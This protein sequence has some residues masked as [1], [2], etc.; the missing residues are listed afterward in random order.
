[1]MQLDRDRAPNCIFILHRR[2]T[3]L[4]LIA[5]WGHNVLL[6]TIGMLTIAIVVQLAT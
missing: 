3:M 6:T 4:G 2:L 1:M 5:R